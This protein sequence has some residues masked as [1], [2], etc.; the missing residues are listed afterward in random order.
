MGSEFSFLSSVECDARFE[1]LPGVPDDIFSRLSVYVYCKWDTYIHIE[2]D[3]ERREERWRWGRGYRKWYNSHWWC[4]WKDA[5]RGLR[6]RPRLLWRRGWAN[7][8][9]WST[10]MLFPLPFSFLRPSSSTGLGAGRPIEVNVWFDFFFYSILTVLPISFF[11][12][13]ARTQQSF[14]TFPLLTRIFFL[15]LTGCVYAPLSFL[16]DFLPP[17]KKILFYFLDVFG[18]LYIADLI[19]MK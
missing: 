17:Q 7:S 1:Y 4:W 14:F 15:G 10:P 2:R 12:F 16:L 19:N 9:S 3:R 8:C 5:Q 18:L 6:S 11:F 13:L